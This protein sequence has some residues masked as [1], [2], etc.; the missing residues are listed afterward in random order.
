MSGNSTEP[1]I[2]PFR[3]EYLLLCP[4]KAAKINGNIYPVPDPRFPFL[5]VHFTPRMNGEVAGPKKTLLCLS[6]EVPIFFRAGELLGI[7]GWLKC[8]KYCCRCGLAPTQ[9]W[10]LSARA[11]LGWTSVPGTWQRF[12]DILDFTG[13]SSEILANFDATYL[14]DTK[15]FLSRNVCRIVGLH[16]E[17]IH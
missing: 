8:Y 13:S 7:T 12:F 14:K 11:T 4:E 5:G 9:F 15:F 10:P 16:S 6:T 2:V 1:R 17:E 3:G